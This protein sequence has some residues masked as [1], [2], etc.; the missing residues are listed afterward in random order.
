VE[1]GDV[2]DPHGTSSYFSQQLPVLRGT[3]R[4]L[5]LGYKDT[6][7]SEQIFEVEVSSPTKQQQ[8]YTE[9][10]RYLVPFGALISSEDVIPGLISNSIPSGLLNNLLSLSEERE[11]FLLRFKIMNLDESSCVD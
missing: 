11:L 6:P 7:R 3:P 10:L 2:N 9:P 8:K 4:S 1:L 5:P